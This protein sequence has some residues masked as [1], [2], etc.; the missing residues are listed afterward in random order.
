MV[1]T[2][3]FTNASGDSLT[4]PAGFPG[5][6]AFIL[7]NATGV[8]DADADLFTTGGALSDG[9]VWQGSRIKER[10]I[11]LTLRDK[12]NGD[13]ATNRARLFS[14]FRFKEEGIVTVSNENG[15][16]RSIAAVVENVKPELKN[17]SHSYQI[18]LICPNPYWSDES[19]QEVDVLSWVPGWEFPV[20]VFD[21]SGLFEI[22]ADTA[23]E[24]VF[25]FGGRT[26]SIISD[27]VNGGDVDCGIV[28]VFSALGNVSNPGILNPDTGEILRVNIDMAAGDTLEVDTRYGH[29]TAVL[30][31]GGTRSNVFRLIDPDSVFIQLKPGVN[32]IKAQ[33][34]SADTADL[35]IS[36]FFDNL[37]HSV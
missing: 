10:N 33:S 24:D 28:V 22:P 30:D 26:E 8:L 29:R 15:V 14:V 2:I 36:I 16:A 5:T 4:F 27:L 6:S 20:T 21:D 34:G 19:T 17:R 31:T 23:E 32:H 12:P 35:D 9:V 7:Q 3:T 1:K 18:S 37:Y 11:V 25:E 13:H